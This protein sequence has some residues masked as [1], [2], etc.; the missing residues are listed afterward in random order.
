MYAYHRFHYR[1]VG[2]QCCIEQ[3]DIGGSIGTVP[4]Q[5]SVS[6]CSY[7]SIGN[8]KMALLICFRSLGGARGRVARA[9]RG[10][11]KYDTGSRA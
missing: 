3:L 9:A 8:F 11:N 7:C 1:P 2:S 10:K 5:K 4:L 6:N